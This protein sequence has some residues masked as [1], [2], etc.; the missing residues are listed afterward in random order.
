MRT[1][2]HTVSVI[3][4]L[5][6][7]P[8]NGANGKFCIKCISHPRPPKRSS[9]WGY[10]MRLCWRKRFSGWEPEKPRPRPQGGCCP[11]RTKCPLSSPGP[12]TSGTEPGEVTCDPLNG[13]LSVLL[14]FPYSGFIATRDPAPVSVPVRRAREAGRLQSEP[15]LKGIM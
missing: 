4:P 5:H 1:A 11:R 8:K 15:Y 2:A 13:L 12:R 3:M 6:R 10:L 7:P 9:S 14:A